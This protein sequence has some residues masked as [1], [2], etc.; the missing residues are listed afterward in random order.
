MP[1]FR[2]VKRRHLRRPARWRASCTA[3]DSSIVVVGWTIPEEDGADSWRER[4]RGAICFSRDWFG[5]AKSPEPAPAHGNGTGVRASEL[6]RQGLPCALSPCSS[7]RRTCLHLCLQVSARQRQGPEYDELVE[8][9]G[10]A[11]LTDADLAFD[12]VEAY[13]L[14]AQA[15]SGIL[16]G[17]S[18]RP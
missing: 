16:V 11:A 15:R 2:S 5:S 6:G 10:T 18:L 8:V 1:T 3:C 17:Q 14:R 7:K 13:G 12:A 9:A 4:L